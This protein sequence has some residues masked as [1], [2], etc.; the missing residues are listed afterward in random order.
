VVAA[1]TA[2]HTWDIGRRST[3]AFPLMVHVRR[4]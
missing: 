2:K 4:G 3:L 1:A